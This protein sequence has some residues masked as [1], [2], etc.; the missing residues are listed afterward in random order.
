MRS[1]PLCL[2]VALLAPA[3]VRNAAAQ[4]LVPNAAVD[5]DGDGMSD[6]LE[7]A[8]L[9]QFAPAFLV[10]RRDCSNLPAEF[11]P[12]T[13][14]PTV[15]AEEGALYGQVFPAKS[16][17]GALPVAE[18]HY[19]HLWRR[20]CGPHGHPLDTEHVSVLVS[21]SQSSSATAKWKADYWYAG[22][23]ENTICDVSH[24]ARAAT[25]Q[26]TE[27]GAKVWISQGK[28]ASYLN[29]ALCQAGCA[30]DR[31]ANTVALHTA[32][33]INLGE[34]GHPMNGAAFIASNQWPLLEKMSNTNFPSDALARLNK[35]PETDIAWFKAG[36]HPAY[37]IVSISSA[38]EQTIAG[39][40]RNTTSA[41]STAGSSTD[42]AI[43]IA[44]DHT[45]NALGKSYRHTKH[46]L[47]VS[48]KHVGKALHVSPEPAKAEAPSTG[49]PQR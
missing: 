20:D 2:F 31:C 1:A 12:N 42:T 5:S 37:Q 30:A 15:K 3:L 14:A 32:K 13:T 27:H 34:P 19:Y 28:H 16:S 40:A 8:L 36:K 35:L 6:A 22:A 4:E 33:I 9:V 44:Q 7:Q 23:H 26:A 43:S 25:L 17:T 18:I 10:E 49:T 21:A 24:L 39:G 29:P 46:A 41:L 11:E 47:G 38:T 45:G 48:A